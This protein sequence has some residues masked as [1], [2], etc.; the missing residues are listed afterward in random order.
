MR[1][2]LATPISKECGIIQLEVTRNASGLNAFS[3][4]YILS[5][6]IKDSKGG[7]MRQELMVGKKKLVNRT[8]NYVL[9]TDIKNPKS[10]GP[11]YLGKLRASTSK[12]DEYF[13]FGPGENPT[14]VKFSQEA[15]K[16]F[17]LVK[18]E[19]DSIQGLGKVK[20]T[21]CFLPFYD[22]ED[23][24]YFNRPYEG[25]DDP[26]ELGISKHVHALKNKKPRWSK[27]KQKYV[28]K[29]GSRVKE[30]SNKNTQLIEDF[31]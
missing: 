31:R 22:Y 20:K 27:S 1:Q 30:S 8:S 28:F 6:V 5:L 16:T 21:K 24:K 11:A 15:R 26:H 7:T 17:M 13:L 4:K 19:D 12:K 9:S 29:F 10:K 25:V 2:L 18:F 23:P 3:P 14:R